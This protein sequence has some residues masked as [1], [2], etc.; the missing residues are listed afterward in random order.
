MELLTVADRVRMSVPVE[1][2]REVDVLLDFLKDHNT[3]RGPGYTMGG[4]LVTPS[5]FWSACGALSTLVVG[6]F[7]SSI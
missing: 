7:V 3:L 1:Q 6:T 5:A 2:S 4:Q